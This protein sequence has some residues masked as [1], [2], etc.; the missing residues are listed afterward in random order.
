MREM[1]NKDM[2]VTLRIE[3]WIMLKN[4]WEYYLTPKEEDQ[5]DNIRFA[6]VCG[7]E[8]EMGYIDME[9]LK[10]YIIS[11]TKDLSTL[12]PATGGWTWK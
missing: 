4:G 1:Y 8:N 7:F 2:D 5:P 11:R 10:P 6:M 12:K 3:E 9:E